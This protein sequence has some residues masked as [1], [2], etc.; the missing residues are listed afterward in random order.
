[1]LLLSLTHFQNNSTHLPDQA[2]NHKAVVLIPLLSKGTA[3]IN[4]P[5]QLS[6]AT[7]TKNLTLCYYC[8]KFKTLRSKT[9]LIF[10][11]MVSCSK[12]MTSF[13]ELH[14]GFLRIIPN[15]TVKFNNQLSL[16]SKLLPLLIGVSYLSC[17]ALSTSLHL[18]F[19][20]NLFSPK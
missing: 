6:V 17:K 16:L 19:E 1:M 11:N 9:N 15:F 14:A 20:C 13:H 4:N 8:W 3:I 7:L 5:W 18:Y 12:C 2:C 10:W